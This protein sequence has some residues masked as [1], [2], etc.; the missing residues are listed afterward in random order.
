MSREEQR[1]KYITGNY[2]D[3]HDFANKEGLNYG[4]VRKYAGPEKWNEQRK[5]HREQIVVKTV[6]KAQENAV[7]DAKT[8][9]SETLNVC[10]LVRDKVIGLLTSCKDAKSVNALASALY[11]VN[12]IE[13]GLLRYDRADSKDAKERL[14]EVCEALMIGAGIEKAKGSNDDEGDRTDS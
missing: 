3:L 5:E 6:A 4:T 7:A 8:R 10:G 14:Q 1:T 12:E 2:T 11:R 13:S 9:Q